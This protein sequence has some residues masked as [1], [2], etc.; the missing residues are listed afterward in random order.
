VR[1][2]QVDI[3]GRQVQLDYDEGTITI[4]RVKEILRE[5]EYPVESV[6]ASVAP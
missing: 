2:V 4:E 6:A 5:E 1:A 3:P